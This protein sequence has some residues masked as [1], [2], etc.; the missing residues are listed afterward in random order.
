M[1]LRVLTIIG[2]FSAL[3]LSGCSTTPSSSTASQLPSSRSQ[4]QEVLANTPKRQRA[5]LA[6]AWAEQYADEKRY[7]E[8]LAMLNTVEP[9]ELASTDHQLKWYQLK[10]HALLSENK[11][12]EA[13]LLLDEPH[14][15]SLLKEED[16]ATQ[17]MF[18]L[19]KADALALNGDIQRSVLL[20][21]TIDSKLKPQDQEYNH[22][23]IWQLLTQLSDEEREALSE[24]ANQD[25][26]G[27]IALAQLYQDDTQGLEAQV[28][29]LHQWQRRW[30][31]HPAL[32][33]P[34]EAI[35]NL[36]KALKDR[37]RHLAVL[38]PQ[39]GA[40]A[41]AA[42]ALRDGFMAAYYLNQAQGHDTPEVRFYDSSQEEDILAL[43]HQAVD[44]GAELVIGPLE[45]NKV[46]ALSK[47]KTLPVDVL[48]LNYHDQPEAPDNL[49]QFGLAPEDEAKQIAEVAYFQ[50]LS[51][52][53]LLFPDTA[54][55]HRIAQAFTQAWED[56]GAVVV[57]QQAYGADA[58]SAVSRL[59]KVDAYQARTHRDRNVSRKDID[60]IFLVASADQGRQIKPAIDFYHGNRLPLF[61]TSMIYDGQD[62]PSKNNDLNRIQFMDIPWLIQ[63]N[64]ELLEEIQQVW[65]KQH[66]RYERIFALGMDAYQV[67]QRLSVMKTS[68]HNRLQGLTGTLTLNQQRIER[69]LLPARFVRGKATFDGNKGLENAKPIPALPS[70]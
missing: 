16:S 40:V 29:L 21:F 15:T 1:F 22:D 51:R 66:G 41:G 49:F 46:V 55:G 12:R 9:Q 68:R 10:A 65:P 28:K 56:L 37:P 69:G 32:K 5:E 11:A 24:Q 34:P 7:E 48:S 61:S 36:E 59:L 63:P 30:W 58:N 52:M 19:L 57:D 39:Q 4:A 13:S 62:N 33:N 70:Q 38:L 17:A 64:P 54:S 2:L 45:K 20:R 25:G 47:Q 53:G 6:L 43:Y 60:A 14:L 42:H 8:A 23:L 3:I 26:Q 50:G 44:E 31:Q 67:A 18:D 27:W 35:A